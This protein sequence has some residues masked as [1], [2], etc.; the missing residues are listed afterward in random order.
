MWV[1]QKPN[2]NGMMWPTSHRGQLT[3]GGKLLDPVSPSSS[4]VTV[5]LNL[6]NTL[7]SH[8]TSKTPTQCLQAIKK[9]NT[10]AWPINHPTGN[11]ADK[12]RGFCVRLCNFSFAGGQSQGIHNSAPCFRGPKI[13]PFPWGSPL[14]RGQ[15]PHMEGRL[16]TSSSK[17][18]TRTQSLKL[19]MS[20]FVQMHRETRKSLHARS[21]A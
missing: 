1:S 2:V 6:E 20:S 17:T 15:N 18:C 12:T 7:L 13:W 16:A 19:K 11:S 21:A 4:S 10:K 9:A 5:W 14:K 3:T 8:Q